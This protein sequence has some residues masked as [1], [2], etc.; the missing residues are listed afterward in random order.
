MYYHRT[1]EELELVKEIETQ[2]QIITRDGQ[3]IEQTIEK[4]VERPKWVSKLDEEKWAII[5]LGGKIRVNLSAAK[6]QLSLTETYS[7]TEEKY[8]EKVE[9]VLAD[10]QLLVVGEISNNTIDSGKPF[11]VTNNSDEQLIGSLESSEKTL[12]WVLKIATLLLF[13]FG[14]YSLLGP[15]LLVLDAIPIL[16]NIGKTGL[17]IVSM[18]IGFLFTIF[19]SLIIA[20]WYIILIIIAV[21]VV[22]LI[23]AKRQSL[24][25]QQEK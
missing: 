2:T 17:F 23:Y 11:I 20:F 18:L 10:D 5:V 14:L 13:G 24:V 9:A 12:W 19:S 21:L 15:V 3:D 4:E 1:R 25:V 22:Y 16:G 6:K 7:I 8:R